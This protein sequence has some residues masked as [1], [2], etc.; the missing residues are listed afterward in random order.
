MLL[1]TLYIP[2][3]YFYSDGSWIRFTYML[4]Q[5]F[6]VAIHTVII[7]LYINVVLMVKQRYQLITLILSKKLPQMMSTLQVIWM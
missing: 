2:L 3:L 5:E 7:L 4:M 1:G 6:R